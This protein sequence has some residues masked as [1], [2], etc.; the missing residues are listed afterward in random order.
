M[1][2]LN[3]AIEAFNRLSNLPDKANILSDDLAIIREYLSDQSIRASNTTNGLEYL[4][5]EMDVVNRLK[6]EG[7]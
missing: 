6:A 5:R 2:M 4:N 3:N 7:L 1:E